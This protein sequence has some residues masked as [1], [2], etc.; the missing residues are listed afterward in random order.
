MA[1]KTSGSTARTS[2]TTRAG[3]RR[4]AWPSTSSW[5]RSSG[6]RSR[7]ACTSGSRFPAHRPA[8]PSDHFTGARRAGSSDRL[9]RSRRLEHARQHPPPVRSGDVEG[10][11][12]EPGAR[13]RLPE[14]ALEP[15]PGDAEPPELGIHL[16]EVG[17]ADELDL[18]GHPPP[19]REGVVLFTGVQ[20]YP[21]PLLRPTQRLKGATRIASG[22]LD[23]HVARAG[24]AVQTGVVE[25]ARAEQQLAV[26]RDGA[27]IGD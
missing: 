24:R 11:G 21:H 27:R 13:N 7:P 18:C 9:P 4:S 17:A 16:H 15:G 1:S 2:S 25:E 26:I 22:V 10:G 12:P 5:P 6:L 14:L 23:V 20:T 19:G 8:A 3:G